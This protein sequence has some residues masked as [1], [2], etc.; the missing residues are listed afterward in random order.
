MKSPEAVL[1]KEAIDKE[2]DAL[3]K[4]GT[5]EVCDLPD[6]RKS[7]RC[8][9]VFKRKLNSANEI[10]RY[11]ARLV[12]K[13]FSQV[14]GVDFDETLAAVARLS[15]LRLLLS[16]AAREELDLESMDAI[17]AFLNGGLSEEIY[18]NP[19]E[20]SNMP[21]GLVVRLLKG[22]YGLQQAGRVWWES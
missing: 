11:K 15:G 6:A 10:L 18:M 7:I 14:P 20:G 17:N 19:P 1:W 8:R 21:S 13:G 4:N 22:L 2:L 3:A 12:A 9:W 5:W 16:I